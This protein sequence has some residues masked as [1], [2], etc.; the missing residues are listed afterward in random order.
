MGG[1]ENNQAAAIGGF[2]YISEGVL[3]NTGIAYGGDDN[4]SYGV[5]LTVGF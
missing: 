1:Y 3:L 5:G 4:L 2:H